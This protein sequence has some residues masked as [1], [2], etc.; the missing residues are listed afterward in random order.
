LRKIPARSGRPVFPGDHIPAVKHGT[1]VALEGIDGSGKSTQLELLAEVL[2]GRGHRVVATREPTEGAFGRRIRAMA[3]GG[4]PPSRDEELRWFVEDRR[5]HVRDLVG[6]SLEAG[7]VVLT[8]RYYLSTVAY[9]GARGHDP[10]RLLRESE[11]E[12]PAPDLAIVLEIEPKQGLERV[13][14]RGGPVEPAFEEARFLERV[15]EILAGIDRAYVV[16]IDAARPVDEVQA[17][18]LDL[19][20]SRLGL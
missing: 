18:I 2:R 15:A 1:L 19:M 10:D 5:E 20:D 6:P 9:Q 3:K 16:R 4:D 7:S 11:A 17:D 12:F 8:D 13:Q 14:G